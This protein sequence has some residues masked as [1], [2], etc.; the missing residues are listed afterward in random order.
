MDIMRCQQPAKNKSDYSRAE[1]GKAKLFT[2]SNG[3]V[4]EYHV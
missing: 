1:G 4:I 3:L 2:F